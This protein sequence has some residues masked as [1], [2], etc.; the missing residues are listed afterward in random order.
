MEERKTR[1]KEILCLIVYIIYVSAIVINKFSKSYNVSVMTASIMYTISIIVSI[2][3]IKEQISKL[4]RPKITSMEE[5]SK[6]LTKVID[7]IYILA[8]IAVISGIWRYIISN[9]TMLKPTTVN[10]ETVDTFKNSYYLIYKIDSI[11]ITPIL[12][13]CMNRYLP[14]QFIRNK[15]LYV[16]ISAIIFAGLHVIDTPYALLYLPLYLPLS[17]YLGYVFYKTEN[18][19]KTIAMH[20]IYNMLP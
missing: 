5:I 14:F 2:I 3:V 20:S 16:V 8:I 9:Y 10:Q 17:L 15:K 13:E 1:C 11:I 18:I 19:F 7:Y 4:R 12:E 6:I